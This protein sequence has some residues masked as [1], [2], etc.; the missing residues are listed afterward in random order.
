MPDFFSYLENSVCVT[1]LSKDACGLNLM[2]LFSPFGAATR[3]HVA[4][5][6]KTSKSPIQCVGEMNIVK[7]IIFYN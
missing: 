3:C 7:Y 6:Q 1:N 2:E 4:I 5:D